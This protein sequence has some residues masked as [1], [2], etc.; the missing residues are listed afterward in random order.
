MGPVGHRPSRRRRRACALAGADRGHRPCLRPRGGARKARR[1]RDAHDPRRTRLAHQPVPLAPVQPQ[2]GRV[3]RLAREPLPP[4]R[5]GA[6]VRAQGR[7]PVLPD[8][9]PHE[10][11]RVLRGRLRP[12]GGR[13]HCPGDRALRRPHP[14]IRRHVP[15]DLR[16]H[17]PLHVRGSR[18]Q[19]LPCR[20]DQAPREQAR[21]NPRRP[22]RSGA[23]GEDRGL[24]AGGRRVHG[25]RSS[26]RSLPSAQGDRGTRRRDRALPA[27]LHVHGGARGNVGAPLHR[28]PAHRPRVRGRRGR[29]RAGVPS[30]EG[31]RCGRWPRRPVRGV[32]RG[33]AWPRRAAVREGGRAR[34]HPQER[35]RV[36][37]QARD[38]RAH[39]HLRASGAQGRRAD[40]PELR[41]HARAGRGSTA[42][43]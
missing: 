22:E 39:G 9:V 28:E 3:R 10:R 16:H 23:D 30:Q 21:R 15:E 5:R 41:G 2:D 32:H 17:P 33:A 7:G 4:C 14:R 43:T 38:V 29:S 37:V 6:E 42:T 24:G 26:R 12:G 35:A 1:L 20:K 25:A 31:A 40:S 27:L 34:R 18:P 8:R 11:R 36:A 13:A 19:R